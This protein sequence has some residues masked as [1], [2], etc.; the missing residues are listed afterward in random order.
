MPIP[1]LPVLLILILSRPFVLNIT[2]LLFVVPKKLVVPLMFELP[3]INQLWAF[4]VMHAVTKNMRVHRF[5]F[6]ELIFKTVKVAI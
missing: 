2:G 1:T 3:F 4:T 5:L 6:I